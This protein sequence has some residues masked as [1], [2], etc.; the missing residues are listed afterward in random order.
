LDHPVYT[1]HKS[2]ISLDNYKNCIILIWSDLM[3]KYLFNS[4]AWKDCIFSPIY[5]LSNLLKKKY[6]FFHVNNLKFCSLPI[7]HKKFCLNKNLITISKELVIN[8]FF[9]KNVSFMLWRGLVIF[10]RSKLVKNR[11]RKKILDFCILSVWQ[12]VL[13]IMSCV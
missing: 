2:R 8:Y 6:H 9:I 1:V 12:G 11:K 10:F 3:F 4:L 5:R 7:P 13:K